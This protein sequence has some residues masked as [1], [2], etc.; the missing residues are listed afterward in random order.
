MSTD[1]EAF[2]RLKAADPAGDATLD[3]DRIREAVAAVTGVPLAGAPAPDELAGRRRRTRTRWMQAAA[4][5]A[6]VAVVGTGGYLAG[7][8]GG[9]TDGGALSPISLGDSGAAAP[10]SGGGAEMA[11]D[12]PQ[13]A[14]DSMLYPGYWGRTVFTGQGLSANGGS[15]SA[16]GFD[17][18]VA[19]AATAARIAAA[20]GVPG[21]PR[22]EWGSWVVGPNDGSGPTVSVGGD[23]MVSVNYYDPARDPWL[24]Q[25]AIGGGASGSTGS[26][27]VVEPMPPPEVVGPTAPAP[28]GEP[29]VAPA[30][31][32]PASDADLEEQKA[33][34]EKM[35][36]E[37]RARTTQPS[38]ASVCEAG[39]TP[40]GDGAT[41]KA[42]EVLAAIG[43][44]ASS[45]EATVDD[46]SVKDQGTP[47]AG[48]VWVSLYQVLD[49]QRTGVQWNV[50]LVGNGVQSL[51]ATLAPLVDLGSYDVVSPAEAVERLG[52]PRFGGSGGVIAYGREVS[53]ASGVAVDEPAQEPTV[54][55]A[56]VPGAAI[57]WPVQQVTLTSARLGLAQA[58]LANGA[59]VLVPAYELSDAAGST[60][61]V[62]AVV[63]SRLDFT[64]AG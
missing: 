16:Y 33:L 47:G 18:S 12:S 58:T 15:A 51:Y 62:I 1:D 59:Q 45:A 9:G 22:A 5:V 32:A 27:G 4:A 19:S 25:D 43:V 3:L 53:V 36:I 28:A 23:G 46:A 41:A 54:P 24:C 26:G 30:P 64:A 13:A 37:E 56:P 42:R 55:P 10:A 35:A 57:S 61:S 60:W 17:A 31:D 11:A 6:A 20:L 44:D 7:A 52:D 38:D 14:R 39:S 50:A 63:D 49:G 34:L 29:A 8:D 21:E 2:D 48:Y 40:T